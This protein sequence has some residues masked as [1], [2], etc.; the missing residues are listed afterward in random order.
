MESIRLPKYIQLLYPQVLDV[1][2]TYHSFQFIN[3]DENIP[4]EI[5]EYNGI[6]YTTASLVQYSNTTL[7][8]EVKGK[9]NF[10]LLSDLEMLVEIHVQLSSVIPLEDC[11]E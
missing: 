2:R 11:G 10:N 5:S 1:K 4:F 6:I 8:L 7:T 3:S 9:H